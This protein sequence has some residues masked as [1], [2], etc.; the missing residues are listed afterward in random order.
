MNIVEL[1]E[2]KG[3]AL[4]CNTL[5]HC[6]SSTFLF[7]SHRYKMYNYNKILPLMLSITRKNVFQRTF[8]TGREKKMINIVIRF[9]YSLVLLFIYDLKLE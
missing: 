1:F 6:T 7:F 8:D 9:C 5:I 2:L 3:S 4:H